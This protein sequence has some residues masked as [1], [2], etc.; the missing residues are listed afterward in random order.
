MKICVRRFLW[1]SEEIDRDAS[2]YWLGVMD[3]AQRN[4]INRVK[5]CGQIMGRSE[6]DDQPAAQIMYPCMQCND[7]FYIGADICQLGADQRKVNML[8]RE[9]V[10]DYNQAN[11]KNPKKRLRKP[12]IVSHG[13]MPGLLEGQE[14]MSKSDPDSAIFMEDTREDISRK[15]KKAFCPPQVIESNPVVT[16]IKTLVF[17][18]YKEFIVVRKPENGGDA[19]YTSYEQFEQ[20]YL[21]GLLHPGDVKPALVNALDKMIQPVRDHFQN[22]PEARALLKEIKS[23]KVTK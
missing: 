8:A 14:K 4:S 15:I 2:N 16:Y 20:D 7:I 3:I 23:F 19:M 22:D 13:M 12:V 17:P 6:G 5:R 10:D 9:Y 11:K 1:T 18:I 21:A